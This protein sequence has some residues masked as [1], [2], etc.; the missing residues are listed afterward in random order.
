VSR[1][2]LP[3]LL[4]CAGLMAELRVKRASAEA[5]MR[6]LP[7]VELPGL[8]TVFVRRADVVE[9]LERSTRAA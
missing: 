2:H 7:K 4:D 5:I 1:K 3:E 9:L 6:Q 8:R